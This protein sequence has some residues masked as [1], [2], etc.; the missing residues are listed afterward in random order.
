MTEH[1]EHL[2]NAQVENYGKRTSHAG[3]ESVQRDDLQRVAD[4]SFDDWRLQDHRVDDHF[5][6]QSLDDQRIEA[7]LAD[8]SSCRNRLLDFHCAHFEILIVP[9]VTVE[10][11]AKPVV[12]ETSITEPSVQLGVS[13]TGPS[14]A[15]GLGFSRT[16]EPSGSKASETSSADFTFGDARH[17]A[18]PLL[19]AASTPECP[20]DDDLRQLAAGLSP[21]AV[22]TRLTQHAATCDHCGPLLRTFTE[23]FSDDFSPEEQAALASLQSSSAA[24]QKKTARQ[25][26]QAAGVPD[27]G[28]SAA[29][30][31]AS[32]TAATAKRDNKPDKKSSAER[33]ASSSLDRKPF[34]WRWVLV[35]AS[36]AVVAVSAFTIW[37]V[38]R[39]TPEKVEKLLAQAYTEQRTIELR[40]PGARYAPIRIERA[41]GDSQFSKPKSLIEA[42]FRISENL[43]KRPDDPAILKAKAEAELLTFNYKSAITTLDKA[44]RSAPDSPELLEALGVAYYESAEH[45]PQE[46]RQQEYAKALE[47]M[48]IA[49][50]RAPRHTSILFNHAILQEKMGLF[51]QAIADWE[52]F[53]GL[54]REGGWREEAQKR[55]ADIRRKQQLTRSGTLDERAPPTDFSPSL[56]AGSLL[57]PEILLQN[58]ERNILPYI[59]RPNR[60]DR[61]FNNAIAIA[62]SLKSL[63]GDPFLNDVL[64][65]A[66]RPEF[67]RGTRM[68]AK[69]SLENSRGEAEAAYASAG[70]AVQT[71]RAIANEAGVSAAL[72]EQAYS[73]QFQSKA[74][75]CAKKA[76]ESLALAQK[77]GYYW[78]VVQASIEQATCLNMQ[79]QLGRA[80]SLCDKAIL[81]ARQHG[82]RSFY[83]R[84]LLQR[85]AVKEATGDAAG[86]W[87]DSFAGLEEYF[88]GG[89][90]D[91]RAYSFYDLISEI[92]EKSSLDQVKLAA[93]LEQAAFLPE[94]PNLEVVA[95]ARFR[96]A[97]VALDLGESEIAEQQFGEASRL[98]SKLPRTDSVRW[99]LLEANIGL[100]RAQLFDPRQRDRALITLQAFADELPKIHNRYVERDYFTTLGEIEAANHKLAEAT[101]AYKKAIA[102]A[103]IERRSSQR[104]AD[105]MNWADQNRRPYVLLSNLLFEMQQ[106]AQAL[107]VWSTFRAAPFGRERFTK[108]SRY[109]DEN[110]NETIYIQD[111]NSDLHKAVISYALA[112]D[113]ILVWVD[114][115]HGNSARKISVSMELFRRVS[116]RF[117]DECSRPDSPID[118]LQADSRMLYNWLIEPL[119]SQLP[120]SGKLY[121][122]PD[123]ILQILPWEAL[124]D[125][126]NSY[127]RE[128][129]SIVIVSTFHISANELKLSP[130]DTALIVRGPGLVGGD[131]EVEKIA[132]VFNQAKVLW[133]TH[134]NVSE[135]KREINQYSVLYFVGHA[136]QQ[137]NGPAL[138]LTDGVFDA[139]TTKPGEFGW[140]KGERRHFTSLKLAV[141]SACSTAHSG[142]GNGTGMAT[143]VAEF[144]ESGAQTVIASRWN[145]DS[146]STTELMASFYQKLI[147]GLPLS[148]ALQSAVATVAKDSRHSHPYYWAAFG[149]FGGN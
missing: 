110:P 55:L 94:N 136:V 47:K 120:S 14:K 40:F 89:I 33:P 96:V 3:A 147:G 65:A 126:S 11:V 133:G 53:L 102:L 52:R 106:P 146:S 20:S 19:R 1:S 130:S 24:W 108:S 137:P 149:Q 79:G 115:V 67:L 58:A 35:A 66:A 28:T 141:L 98:V 30:I 32:D 61:Q 144:L 105:A 76:A 82:L 26:L 12:A 134:A 41:D 69:A 27:V 132:S 23:D 111:R 107:S 8:C 29:S 88:R 100:A 46:Y 118:E 80:K 39:D 43:E 122:K 38:V 7:H 21:N 78:L 49:L 143:L 131:S 60:S 37:Y 114:G 116:S 99:R 142:Y 91:I 93:A 4:R 112:P 145:I 135:L 90:S 138:V 127:L 83:L 44:L 50:K 140:N 31:A 109:A 62:G 71:F 85:S 101:D 124:V 84:A 97:N 117:M 9:R 59:V 36:V 22:A 87:T 54:E 77:R 81:V 57:D 2:S 48:S 95:S 42:E 75:T 121:I 18:D 125:S 92:A 104:L 13:E 73:L 15:A 17:P 119:E 72:F 25:M 113:G 10:G 16:T 139:S 123:G 63:H 148:G 34:F 45:G 70:A 68:L 129:Y 103:E 5:H 56:D 6:G 86:A 74:I 64:T 51:N 128:R